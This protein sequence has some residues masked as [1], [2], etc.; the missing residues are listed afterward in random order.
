MEIHHYVEIKQHTLN[1]Q[2]VREEITVELE[3]TLR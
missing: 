2:W 1:H 3:N